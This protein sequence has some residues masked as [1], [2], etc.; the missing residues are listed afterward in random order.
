MSWF[1]CIWDVGGT[2]YG[3]WV[4]LLGNFRVNVDGL[5]SRGDAV[6]SLDHRWR[7]AKYHI[8]FRG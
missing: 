4:R 5:R 1:L 3:D 6:S 2:Y 8:C 7:S